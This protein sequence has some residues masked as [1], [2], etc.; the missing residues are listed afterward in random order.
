[1]LRPETIEVQRR[2][3]AMLPPRSTTNV[4]LQL[5]RED[6]LDVLAYARDITS[7]RQR[8]RPTPDSDDDEDE[9]VA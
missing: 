2:S 6:A 7:L 9:R 1:M 8:A 4:V 5:Q 3:V